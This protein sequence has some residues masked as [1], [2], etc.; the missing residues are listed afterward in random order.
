MT[1]L[2]VIV[3]VYNF[4]TKI[5]DNLELLINKLNSFEKNHELIIIDDGSS[6][7][8]VHEI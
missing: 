2:S 7:G 5:I 6:D 8:T 1:N 4:K 3:P